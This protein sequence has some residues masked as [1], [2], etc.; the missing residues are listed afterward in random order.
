MT[1]KKMSLPEGWYPRNRKEVKKYIDSWVSGHRSDITRT[2]ISG[3]VPHAGWYFSGEE[4]FRVFSLISEGIDTIIIAGG[5]LGPYDSPMIQDYDG[6]ETPTGTLKINRFLSSELCKKMKKDTR[7]DNTVEIHLPVIAYL[8]PEVSILPVRLPPT[9]ESFHWGKIAA[10]TCKRLGFNSVFIGSTDLTHYGSNYGNSLYSDKDDPVKE[11]RTK[12]LSLLSFL[13]RGK[14]ED[15]LLWNEKWMTSCSLGAA[16]GATGFAS[17]YQR[18]PGEILSFTN[19][20]EKNGD[21]SSF[22]NYGT[23]VF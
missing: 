12:D 21:S 3:I 6:F 9:A 23:V 10:E 22:V 7:I 2:V 16:L 20:V 13:A 15:A 11:A 17:Y 1:V 5:H 18:I 14:I 8:F 19:S 4:A